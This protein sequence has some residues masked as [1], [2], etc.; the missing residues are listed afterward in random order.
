MHA[1]D[2]HAAVSAGAHVAWRHE[3]HAA[4]GAPPGVQRFASQTAVH[5]PPVPHAHWP[6]TLSAGASAPPLPW[7]QQSKH[8]SGACAVQVAVLIV[9]AVVAGGV[10]LAGGGVLFVV[11]GSDSD[12]GVV[13]F[14]GAAFLLSGT[15][16]LASSAKVLSGIAGA[17]QAIASPRSIRLQVADH[18][19]VSRSIT[20]VDRSLSAFSTRGPGVIWIPA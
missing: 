1:A 14:F 5:W 12:A 6:K 9:G 20:P 2:V 15:A 18:A 11:D 3:E 4:S 7:L 16:P 10:V 17:A 19:G 8:A 13:A